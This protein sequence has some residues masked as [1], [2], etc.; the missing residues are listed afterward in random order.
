MEQFIVLIYVPLFLL[1][2]FLL[3]VFMLANYSG[4]EPTKGSPSG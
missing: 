1:L 2:V 4:T 3:A